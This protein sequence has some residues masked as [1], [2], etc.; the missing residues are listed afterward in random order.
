MFFFWNCQEIISADLEFIKTVK[1]EVGKSN[2]SQVENI[3]YKTIT[4]FC[5]VYK[6]FDVQR[7]VK[8]SK[9][10]NNKNYGELE[11]D[12]VLYGKHLLRTIPLIAFEINGGEHFGDA[13]RE[14][15]DKK[16]IEVCKKQKIKLIV[17]PNSFA[18]AY[19]EIKQTIIKISK[20]KN[21]FEQLNLFD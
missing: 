11:F 6:S 12:C 14:E 8:L 18:K 3:F 5:S 16:K 21:D 1:L 19:E 9:L 4:H 10:F 13:V 7:N 20:D 2:D 17:V 15:M